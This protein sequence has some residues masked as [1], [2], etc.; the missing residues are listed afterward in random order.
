MMNKKTINRPL[1]EQEKQVQPMPG[2]VDP[3]KVKAEVF[4]AVEKA[5]RKLK[6]E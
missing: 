5:R 1:T 2:E 3:R 4:L 6:N